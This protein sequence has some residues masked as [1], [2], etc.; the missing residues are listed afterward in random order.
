MVQA[1]GQSADLAYIQKLVVATITTGPPV[2]CVKLVH[3][4]PATGGLAGLDGGLRAGGGEAEARGGGESW[5]G[6]G[7]A[8]TLGGG[9]RVSGGGG[10]PGA[11]EP[12]VQVPQLEELE[13]TRVPV[14]LL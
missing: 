9:E 1:V 5:A 2:T 11:V 14:V 12:S 10:D 4:E 6:G 8:V 7:L 3:C 13:A